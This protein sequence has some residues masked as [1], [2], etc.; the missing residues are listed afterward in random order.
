MHTMGQSGSPS[1]AASEL[2][3]S[4]VI[5]CYRETEHLESS[6]QILKDT[7][8]YLRIQYEVIFVED[9]SGDG[10][11]EIVQK[12]S[13]DNPTAVGRVI[14]HQTNQGRGQ[15]VMDGIRAARGRVVGFIDIDLE[16]SPH[17]IGPCVM[18]I[19][20][21]RADVVIGRRVYLFSLLAAHRYFMSKFYLGLVKAILGIS[22]NDTE[23]G[24]KFFL[25]EKVLPLL[26]QCKDKRWFWDT[27]IMIRVHE[28]GLR[29]L[30]I[31]C[32]FQRRL[33]K[34]STV[35]IFSD[36]LISLR[37]LIEYRRGGRN[38]A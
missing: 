9:A 8:E 30:E 36:S 19:L 13:D 26:D 33:D 37:K 35:K 3:L 20:K 29:S 16:V 27:E 4:L 11:L 2:D 18:P 21:D 17:Y 15:T 23:T 38:R 24:Y 6:F 14:T 12:L 25:R 7:L 34:T 10:T 5:P 32:L 28:A 22:C 1:G 31:P